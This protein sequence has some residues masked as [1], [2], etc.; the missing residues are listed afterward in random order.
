MKKVKDEPNERK[1]EKKARLQKTMACFSEGLRRFKAAQ[2]VGEYEA[3]ADCYTQAI[4][5]RA[6]NPTYYFAR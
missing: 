2:T 3:A 1:E 4:E 6:N 5:L